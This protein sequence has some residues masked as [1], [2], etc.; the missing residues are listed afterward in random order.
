MLS[1]AHAHRTGRIK[2]KVGAGTSKQVRNAMIEK[3]GKI[4]H[5]IR[6]TNHERIYSL[7]V[8]L[9][10]EKD[11]RTKRNSIIEIFLAKQ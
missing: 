2:F 1:L 5:F 10:G 4:L 11:D 9:S 6:A 3:V 7:A 8:I